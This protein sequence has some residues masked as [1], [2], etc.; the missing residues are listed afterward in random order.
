MGTKRSQKFPE[1]AQCTCPAETL[2]L[3]VV[4]FFPWLMVFVIDCIPR[5][6]GLLPIHRAQHGTE[7]ILLHTASFKWD[8]PGGTVGKE[9]PCQY[10]RHKRCGFNYW[11]RKIPWRKKWQPTPAFLPGKFHGQG[12]LVGYSP[13]GR[14]DSDMTSEW[15]HT[16]T[17]A[18]RAIADP[19]KWAF[20]LP[21]CWQCLGFHSSAPLSLPLPFMTL[22]NPLACD[23]SRMGLRLS[24][25]ETGGKFC[26]D[27]V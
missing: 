16:H 9:S 2:E 21:L 26:Y 5:L 11:V 25:N 18:M 8:F 20:S 7:S 1:G 19:T 6:K 27:D 22:L 10:R 12:S 15:T 17:R 23:F 24:S 13:W 14:K 3:S 4:C